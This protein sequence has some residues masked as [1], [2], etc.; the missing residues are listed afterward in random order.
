MSHSFMSFLQVDFIL[1]CTYPPEYPSVVP[2]L[3]VR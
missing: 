3:T 1:T 2:E